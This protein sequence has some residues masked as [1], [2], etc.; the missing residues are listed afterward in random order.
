MAT[1]KAATGRS[2]GKVD[3]PG[4]KHRGAPAATP[5]IKHSDLMIPKVTAA[6]KMRKGGNRRGGQ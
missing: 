3:A 4:K 6:Q 1:R 5:G 2:G